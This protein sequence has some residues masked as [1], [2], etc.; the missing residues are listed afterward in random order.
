VRPGAARWRLVLAGLLAVAGQCA[1]AQ[2]PGQSCRV[3]RKGQLA[4]TESHGRFSALVQIDQQRLPM[5]IDTGAQRAAISAAA[6]DRLKLPPDP[7]RRYRS[8]GIGGA[9]REEHPRLARSVIFGGATWPDYPMQTAEVTRPE[10]AGEPGAPMGLIGAD[11]LSAYD[12]EID[13]PGR[14]LT[15]YSVEGCSGAFIPWTGGYDVLSPEPGPADL[16]V[17][18]IMLNGRRLRA[19]LDTGSNTSSLGQRAALSVGVG[20]EALKADP[21]DSYVG[22]NG[23][24]VGAHRH[25]FETLTVGAAT[26]RNV[27]LSVRNGD[28][29]AF[30]MLLGV[31]FLRSRRVWLSYATRQA[32]IQAAGQ[33]Q[34]R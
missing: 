32:F 33:A 11:M 8:I 10:Q 17:V 31:D 15:L 1:S 12:I 5:L 19:L 21:E 24:A 14:T 26:F 20:A 3:E 6:A 4:L 27:R 18:P 34:G 2:T 7:K 25:Q 9:G 13:F 16:F 22:S 30:D 28:S 29:S 23:A